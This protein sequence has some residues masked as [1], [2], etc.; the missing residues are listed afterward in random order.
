MAVQRRIT[1]IQIRK[2][3]DNNVNHKL[4]WL[5][6]LLGLFNLRDK[7]KSCFRIFIELVKTTKHGMPATSDELSERSR[8]SRGTVV[9]HLNK[10]MDTGMVV[11]ERH[12]YIL[13]EEGLSNLV[14]M[15]EHDCIR[16]CESLKDIAKEIDDSLS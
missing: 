12:G 13:R 14:D 5:G 16:M 10:L 1:I 9:H 11:R 8:L 4:Q 6:S 3:V 2:P 15:I 7:D